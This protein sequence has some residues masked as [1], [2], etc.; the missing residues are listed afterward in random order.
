MEIRGNLRWVTMSH[1]APDLHSN[2]GSGTTKSNCRK[3]KLRLLPFPLQ[4]LP[5]QTTNSLLL[6]SA[7]PI[8]YRLHLQNSTLSTHLTITTT[9]TVTSHST[10]W[11]RLFTCLLDTWYILSRSPPSVITSLLDNLNPWSPS[12]LI[13][14]LLTHLHNLH[15]NNY[16]LDVITG[17]ILRRQLASQLPSSYIIAGYQLVRVACFAEGRLCSQSL[18]PVYSTS[19]YFYPS[20]SIHH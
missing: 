4:R 17:Q 2:S 6:R 10:D 9:S 14:S 13:A 12:Y 8:K 18:T 5:P 15:H 19:G 7:R 3:L 1:Y 11:F 20:S 16:A